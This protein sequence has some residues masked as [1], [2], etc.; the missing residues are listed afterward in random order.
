MRLVGI[1][2]LTTTRESSVLGTV[3]SSTLDAIPVGSRITYAY[4]GD[5]SDRLAYP[6]IN[7][8][9]GSTTGTCNWDQ[10]PGAV[11]AK[12]DFGGRTGRLAGLELAFNVT[13]DAD[14]DDPAA[15]WH[16]DGLYGLGEAR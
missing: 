10:P 3:E 16:W 2:G 5:G 15:I 14:R 8:K 1:F 13:V 4:S 12:C 6:T 9:G 11:L 7:V